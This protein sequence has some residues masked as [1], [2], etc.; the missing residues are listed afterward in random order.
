[1]FWVVVLGDVV[2]PAWLDGDGAGDVLPLGMGE[3]V[4]GDGAGVGA[5]VPDGNGDALGERVWWGCVRAGVGVW[6]GRGRDALGEE[7]EDGDW[8]TRPAGAD[9]GRTYR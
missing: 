5:C 6:V 3:T 1:M 4:V 7:E 2:V 8:V 9:A